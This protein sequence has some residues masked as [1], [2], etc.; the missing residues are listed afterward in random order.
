M[1][2][3]N[4][5][6]VAALLSV[7]VCACGSGDEGGAGGDDR[8]ASAAPATATLG[9]GV[10][11]AFFP[12]QDL[13]EVALDVAPQGGFGVSVLIRT[14]GL[15]AGEGL[16]ADIQLNVEVGEQLA[17]E[18]L[19][20]KSAL[21]CRGSDIGGEVRGVVVGFDPDV[22]KTNDELIALDG[23]IADLVVTVTASDG[24]SATV[25]QPLTIRVGG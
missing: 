11:A 25:R 20:E 3:R 6:I 21:S 24:E 23:Q 7:A 15:A 9:Q 18:F 16:T 4:L 22:Y 12:F 10:G 1:S 5:Q 19:Q 17:G 14:T 8:C 2:C 13:E